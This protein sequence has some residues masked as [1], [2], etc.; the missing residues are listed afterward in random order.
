MLTA[1]PAVGLVYGDMRVVDADGAV[2]QESWL[3]DEPLIPAGAGVIGEL[4]AG[5][6]ATAS[7]L[8]MRASVVEPIP[9]EIPYTDWW[10]ARA[11]A[12]AA[13][14]PTC[15]AA[16]ALPLPRRQHHARRRGPGARA[17]AAQGA[18]V[19]ALVPAPDAAG[20]RVAAR[21]G[22]GAGR[23]S[24]TASASWPRW[25]SR[26][27]RTSRQKCSK[28][29]GW[30]RRAACAPPPRTRSRP[31][32]ATR[33]AS[34]R[35]RSA[36][37]RRAARGRRAAGRARVRGRA[38]RRSRAARRVGAGAAGRARRHARRGHAAGA[39]PR[40]SPR[41]PAELPD[42]VDVVALAQRR[43]RAVSA[44]VSERPRGEPPAPR[45]GAAALGRLAAA[46][47]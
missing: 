47:S 2:I 29:R 39:R 13:R 38:R 24:S 31:P 11:A 36:R 42:D 46:W 4:L 37:R 43:S 10:F 17:R 8:L 30:P 35:G 20:R 41:P 1:R 28:M 3:E 15:R 33:S 45:F 18:D 23:T 19:R 25:A 12:L 9:A 5:N 6:L 32:R 7:S 34:A 21:A 14:S 27:E 16:H 40:R 26:R 22:D 44:I